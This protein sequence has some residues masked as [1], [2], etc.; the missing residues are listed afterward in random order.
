MEERI[1][2]VSGRPVKLDCEMDGRPKPEIIWSFDNEILAE[3][4]SMKFDGHALLINR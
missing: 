1:E 4:E 3:G 2:V